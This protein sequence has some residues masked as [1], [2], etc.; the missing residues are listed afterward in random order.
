VSHALHVSSAQLPP[1]RTAY[2]KVEQNDG[3]R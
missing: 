3:H 2:R 1:D